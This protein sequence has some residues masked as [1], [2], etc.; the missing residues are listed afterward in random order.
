MTYVVLPGDVDDVTVPSG[1]NAYDRRVCH[2]LADM[3]RP[4]REVALAG[5]WPRPDN[6]ARAELTRALAALPD[7]TPVLLDGL[8]ACGVPDVVVPQARR[9]RIAVLVHLPLGDEKGLPPALAAELDT[10]ERETLHAASMVVTTSRWAARRLIDHHGLPASQVHVVP[11]GTDPAPLASGSDGASR[12]L[13]VASVTVRKGQD[14]LI[15]A[16]AAV[17]DLPWSCECA[18]PLSR[19]P[20]H[21]ARLRQLIGRYGLRDRVCL[22]GPKTPERLG[23]TYATADLVV[24][25]SRAETYGMVVTEALAHGIP[26]LATAAGG[27]PEALGR[28]PNPD[29]GVPGILV[30]PDDATALAEALRRWLREPELRRRLRSS[31]R[32][33]RDVLNDWQETSRRMGAVLEQLQGE[34]H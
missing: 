12:L 6:A 7:G 1:G 22:T 8:V 9:L 31:A 19:D 27:I 17:A 28:A 4:V 33:R 23:T 25:P 26:V 16:L 20:L 15:E 10:R 30:P 29:S 3:G 18:G 24:L 14:L 11:P 34:P 5:S 2:G 21:V 13:C 32:H